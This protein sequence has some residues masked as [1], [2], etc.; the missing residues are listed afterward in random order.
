MEKSGS[1]SAPPA[2]AQEA[3]DLLNCV[4]GAGF[5]QE[6]CIRFLNAL[7]DCVLDKKVKKFSL[8]EDN[9]AVADSAKKN[10]Q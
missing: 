10:K 6:K 5:D 7:R 9:N 4:T 8:A 2:C 1:G 3:L